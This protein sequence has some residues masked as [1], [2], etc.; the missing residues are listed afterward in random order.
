MKTIHI[1]QNEIVRDQLDTQ[2]YSFIKAENFNIP[3]EMQ[4]DFNAFKADWENLEADDFLKEGAS[5]RFRRFGLFEYQPAQDL[6]R[7]SLEDNYFQAEDINEYAGGI[8]R[9]FAP[10]SEDAFQNPFVLELI[11]ANF[12]HFPIDENRKK[13]SWIVD[14]HQ[15]R[16]LG[17]HE[18]L[19]EA[20]P[21][22]IH[23]DGEEFIS[24]HLIKRENVKGGLSGIYNN[25]RKL[26]E[27]LTLNDPL[28]SILMWNPFV[29]HGVNP[30]QPENPDHA[31]IRDTLL[32]G[33]NP[34]N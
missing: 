22:G 31:A 23:H 21:E 18:E 24:V 30:I 17:R 11:K 8:K 10:L 32:F 3:T 29:M 16:I 9:R 7:P 19:G 20:T 15:V 27:S 2:K 13:L 12:R 25:D 4:S 1:H 28:D 33:Y 26:I 14:V 34:Q 5:F 6:I